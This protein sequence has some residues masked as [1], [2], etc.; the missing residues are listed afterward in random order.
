MPRKNPVSATDL[1]IAK[2]LE[3]LRLDRQF[4]RQ[5]LSARTG[6][7]LG[8]ITRVELGRM[9][10]RYLDANKLLRGLSIGGAIWPDLRP[11]SPLWLA[12]GKDPMNVDWP[13]ILPA[14]HH[15][16]VDPSASFSSVINAHRDAISAL[17][18]DPATAQLPESWLAAYLTHWDSLHLR[19][20]VVRDDVS[21][22][23]RLFRASAEKLAP[24]STQAARLLADFHATFAE[25]YSRRP[26]EADKK[27]FSSGV[28]SG[29][30]SANLTSM[31]S[32]LAQLL[33]RLNRATEAK[34][35]KAEL[36]EYLKT[37]R[38]C[39]SDW[40]SGKREPSGETTLRL[41]QWV[42]QQ[43]RQ[44]NQS[45][46]SATT[47]PGRKTQSKVSNEKRPK[48]SPQER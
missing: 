20:M 44:Q 19:A 5:E 15:L 6:V 1:A 24:K 12:E 34:G 41:L 28:D 27:I 22:L 29:S 18:S 14:S 47:P 31:K 2:R 45:P 33:Q 39:V 30:E 21:I 7:A 16:G 3:F 35:R 4:S 10:L 11:V 17:I 32:P 37:P 40:L 48:S 25:P 36:A 23:E 43:E 42:E 38:P 46:G 9:A 13:L 26:W 8:I